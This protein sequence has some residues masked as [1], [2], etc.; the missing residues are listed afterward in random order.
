MIPLI[1]ALLGAIATTLTA[2]AALVAALKASREIREVH[3]KINSRMDE[4]MALAKKASYA[5]GVLAGKDEA[6][7]A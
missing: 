3:I 2:I 4:Y 6:K 1:I 7:Q 5:E